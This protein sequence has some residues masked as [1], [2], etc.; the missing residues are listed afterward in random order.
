MIF[1][2]SI[3]N[4]SNTKLFVKIGGVE[5]INDIKFLLNI[6]VDGIIAPIFETICSI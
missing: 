2:L 1:L 6:N 4:K 5:A 3:T